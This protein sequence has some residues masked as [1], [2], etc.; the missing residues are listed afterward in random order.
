M[1]DLYTY[2]DDNG[3]EWYTYRIFS[4][5]LTNDESN[6]IDEFFKERKNWK[7][8]NGGTATFVYLYA[9]GAHK[10]S[11]KEIWNV[12][13]FIK[14]MIV[15]DRFISNKFELYELFKKYNATLCARYMA[16]QYYVDLHNFRNVVTKQMFENKIWILKGIHSWGGKDI[17]VFNQYTDYKNYM[18]N[19]SKKNLD[20]NEKKYRWV[21]AEYIDDVA[22]FEN[23]K[24]HLRVPYLYNNGKGSIGRLFRIGAAKLDYIH[25]DYDNLDIHDTRLKNSSAIFPTDTPDLPT[26]KIFSDILE[27]FYHITKIMNNQSLKCYPETQQCFEV[28]GA[29]VLVT[30]NF[31]VKLLEINSN[32]GFSRL[33][34][35]IVDN[36]LC[37]VIDP[38]L[39]PENP[40]E[41]NNFFVDVESKHKYQKYR[42][43]YHQTKKN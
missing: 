3:K 22:L 20:P 13:S 12:K 7:K 33:I 28:F 32:A 10:K 14:N 27:M 11:G 25:A 6:K 30:A 38:I 4:Y 29:D 40:V 2:I 16:K 23:K 15:Y 43:K 8:V 36:V 26:K 18:E 21:L 24:F 1:T 5:A 9:I 17:H 19:I 37:K 34:D 41:S 35:K 31:E 42:H 39:P